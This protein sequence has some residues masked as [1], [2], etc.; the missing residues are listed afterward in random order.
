M[1]SSIIVCGGSVI[2]LTT[3]M[4]LARDGHDVTVLERDEARPPEVGADAWAG[5]A[6]TGVAQFRQ[7]HNLF[8]RFRLILDE[9]LPG[10]TD[11][12]VDAGCAWMDPMAMLPPSLTDREPRPGDD[13]FRFLTGRRPVVESVLAN[14]AAGHPGVAVRRGVGVAGLLTG[15]DAVDGVPHVTGVITTEG[16]A[17]SADLVV[18]ASGRRSKLADW[19]EAVGA[20]APYVESED[21][22]F[23]YHTRYFTGPRLPRFLGPPV[24]EIG[25]ISILT[26][27]GDN[28][29]WSITVWAA[30]SDTALKPLRDA[31]RFGRVVAA[32]PAHAHWLKGEPISDVLTMAGIL[33][34]YRRF[35]VNGR[36]VATGIAAVGD[37][38]ACTNP[39]AGRGMTVGLIHAQCL[40]DVLRATGDDDPA[41]FAFAWDEATEARVAPFYRDQIREDRTRIAAMDALRDGR[42]PPPP[43]PDRAAAWVAMMHDPDVFRGMLETVMCLALPHE[44]FARPGFLEKIAPFRGAD[45]GRVPGPDRAA[46][47]E[48]VG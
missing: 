33:D 9:D 15:A 47:L 46:L 6:R 30:S 25:T 26:I 37:A 10:I 18:D 40:R 27:P 41:T 3:A 36:P 8:P 43:D 44:V 12:L 4:L 22:G 34:R 39:S 23:V 16:E 45:G 38:W 19:L 24:A 14:A 29:T 11:R 1:A 35:V 7:P 5:W 21:C 31:E 28:G 13:R 20:A 32:C 48:L 17:L 2:G 42:D